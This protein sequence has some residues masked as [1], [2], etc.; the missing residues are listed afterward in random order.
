ERLFASPMRTVVLRP[1]KFMDVWLSALCGF[2]ADRRQATIFGDGAEP[3][4]W[5]A[6]GD[7][8][9][10]AA[11]VVADDDPPEILELGGPQS[12]SQHDVV[13]IYEQATGAAWTRTPVPADELERQLHEGSELESSLAALM[14]EAHL[15]AVT[16]M[17]PVLERYPVRLTTVEEFATR[18]VPT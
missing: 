14:L 2:D 17:T 6:R 16:D 18:A 15:G 4:T 8:A 3:L 13:S 5:I 7:V 11:R 1:G 12:L 9:E 10:L